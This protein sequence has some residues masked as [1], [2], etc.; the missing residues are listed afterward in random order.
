M[1]RVFYAFLIVV[2]ILF[3][4]LMEAKDKK[5]RFLALGDSYT[6]GEKVAEENRWPMQLAVRLREKGI[7]IEKPL[8]IAKTGWTTDELLKG[9]EENNPQGTYDLVSLLI[10]V[11]N[12]YRRYRLTEYSKEFSI[13]LDKAICFA[14]GEPQGVIVL[15]IPDWGV[16]PFAKKMDQKKISQEI[17]EFNKINKKIATQKGVF[18]ID[19]T[20]LSRQAEND[21]ALVAEDGLHPSSEMYKIW[22][23]LLLETALTALKAK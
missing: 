6:I 3:G 13:L 10:G 17:A 14:G 11:N 7:T 18:Y 5:I 4:D 21:M 20:P 9:I 2:F 12:Q 1:Y 23:D 22:V 8:I 16:M 15:S 19:I